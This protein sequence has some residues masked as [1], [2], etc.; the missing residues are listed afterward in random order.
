M[1]QGFGGDGLAKGRGG[2][3]PMHTDSWKVLPA[4]PIIFPPSSNLTHVSHFL[5]HPASPNMQTLESGKER[6]CW[7]GTVQ[8]KK[9]MGAKTGKS[10][11]K[12]VKKQIRNF[13]NK[14]WNLVVS[15]EG[16]WE[17]EHAGIPMLVCKHPW[18]PSSLLCTVDFCG[19]WHASS[20][21]IYDDGAKPPT[22]LIDYRDITWYH[23]LAFLIY[24]LDLLLQRIPPTHTRYPKKKHRWSCKVKSTWGELFMQPSC[25]LPGTYTAA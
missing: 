16:K 9:D 19:S 23:K 3:T 22:Q 25:S 11:K 14:K 10:M 5:S 2:E 24:W 21:A 4:L 7:Q 17:E 13:E 18:N 12:W 8:K 1:R 6:G 20:S 15:N